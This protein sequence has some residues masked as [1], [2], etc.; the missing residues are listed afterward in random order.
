M[1]HRGASSLSMGKGIDSLKIGYIQATNEMDVHWFPSLAFGYLKSYL[2]MHLGD[3]VLM[4]RLDSQED[5]R[6]C[7]IVA[8]SSTSQDYEIARRIAREAKGL[9]Q[10]VITVLGGHHVTYL[11]GTMTSEFDYGVLGEGEET[12]LELVRHIFKYGLGGNPTILRQIKGIAF[13][14]GGCVATTPPR[15]AIFPLDR[16][17]HP[18]RDRRTAPYIMTS[19]GCPYRC[20]FCS[21]SAF[22]GKTRFFSAGY[23]VEEIEQILDTYPQVRNISIQDDLFVAD[24]ERFEEIVERLTAGG[25]NRKASFS[26]AVRAN[27]V[28]DRLCERIKELKVDNVC[29]GAESGSDRILS[30]MKKGTTV[31]RNQ[32]ALDILHAHRIPVLCSFIVGWPTETEEEVRSTY[33][34][35]LGNINA[36]KLTPGSV[37]NILTPMPG[38]ETWRDAVKNGAVTETDFDWNRL[39]VF[40]SYKHSNAATLADWLEKR[41]T[42]NSVYLDEKYLPEKSLYKIMSEF[43]NKV[44]ALDVPPSKSA[45]G[46]PFPLIFPE[47]RLAHKY[48]VGR[49]LEIGGSAHNPFGLN[50]M[51]VDM[52]DSMETTFKKEEIR[53]CGRSLPVNI[54]AGGDAIPRPDESQDFIVSSHVLEHFPNPIK[55]LLE[56][57]RLLRPGGIIFMIVPHKERT[58]DCDKARTPLAHVV[59]DYNRN[60]TTF[61]GD[62]NGHEHYWITEDVVG[63]LRWMIEHLGMN[64]EIAEIQDIDDKV[65]NG[66]TVVIRKTAVL[67]VPDHP[68]G[69]DQENAE[70]GI[71]I[72]KRGRKLRIAIYSFDEPGHACADIRLLSPLN[73]LNGEVEIRWGVSKAE[74]AFLLDPVGLK[75]ADLIIIQRFFP[76]ECTSVFVDRVLRSG[77]PVVY[78]LDDLLFDVPMSNPNRTNAGRCAGFIEK[79]IRSCAAVTV[80]TMDLAREVQP[81]NPF[82][83]VLP[84]LLDAD[85]WF[86]GQVAEG[87]KGNSVRGDRLVIGYSGT[88]TH[89]DDLKSVETALEVIANRY[90]G[91]VE[92]RFMGCA[93]DRMMR[94]PGVSTIRFKPSYREY[95][96]VLRSERFDIAIAPLAD[97]RFNRCKSNIKWLEYGAC[98]IPG[99]YQDLPPYNTSVAHGSTGLLAGNRTQDWVDAIDRMIRCPD[100]RRRMADAARYEV[101]TRYTLAARGSLYLN[102]FREILERNPRG[103]RAGGFSISTVTP[104]CEPPGSPAQRRKYPVSIVIPVFNKVEYTRKCVEALAATVDPGEFIEIVLVDNGSTDGTREFLASLGGDVVVVRNTT[105]FGF[106]AACNQGARVA[107]G[108]NIVFL[109]NDTVPQ[110][111]WLKGLLAAAKE[112]DAA[113]CGGRLVYP[114]GS[115]QHAGVAIDHRGIGYHIFNGF[116]KDHSAV[117]KRR[118]FQAVTAACMLVRRDVFEALGGFDEAYRNGFEDVDLCLRAGEKG[119]R[120]LYAPECVVIHH[121]ETTE[122]RKAHDRGNLERFLSRWQGKVDPDDDRI[123]AEEGFRKI[124]SPDGGRITIEP[125]EEHRTDTEDPASRGRGLKNEKRYVEA[126]EAFR[127]A[128]SVWRSVGAGGHRRLPCEGRKTQGVGGGLPGSDQGKPLRSPRPGGVGRSR[129]REWKSCP[130]GGA[131]HFGH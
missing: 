69:S 101:K 67:S 71:S 28:T 90:K 48:C 125:V 95:A 130:R 89:F 29:F 54:V 115:I 107:R 56:W 82:V 4:E 10:N 122:G 19:R 102:T 36:G 6:T 75:W 38:T 100:E 103:K 96:N 55:A 49:G 3:T 25:I 79:L 106:A 85:V 32:V 44:R 60:N 80:S 78:E 112:E 81:S 30:K 113:I 64:W 21:S 84:N 118:R 35:L 11:P 68:Q 23:V 121:E 5:I 116:P 59:D 14:E 66:F 22:W 58:F 109:N 26:F 61:H 83:R 94:L 72:L 124:V 47:S 43:D 50:A 2:K 127:Q 8:I 129:P 98:G 7:D 24:T 62:P 119:Y 51:N 34:F 128:R 18:I 53:L 39:G 93:T 87:E 111:G 52:T 91:K 65:G 70:H 13:H 73:H 31:A 120:I 9:N 104:P 57:D 88:P 27:L 114:D 74:N 45:S 76:D 1:T 123:Y 126:I 97:N 17:P 41:R 77:I 12:I 46:Q 37:V 20:A 108:R 99:V 131:I 105:N 117:T 86:A 110:P 15:D 63:I 33:E 92:F 40:A 16:I 42:N